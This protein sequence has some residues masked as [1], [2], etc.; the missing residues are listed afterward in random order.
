MVW[1]ELV[2]GPGH[3]RSCNGYDESDFSLSKWLS[4]IGVGDTKDNNAKFFHITV[5]VSLML[6]KGLPFYLSLIV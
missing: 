3:H 6:S 5:D 1:D 4:C 2:V